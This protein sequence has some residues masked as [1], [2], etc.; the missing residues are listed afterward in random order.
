MLITCV[1]HQLVGRPRREPF[2][3][4]ACAISE[5]VIMF[6]WHPLS[7]PIETAAKERGR[8]SIAGTPSPSLL[9]RLLKREGGVALLAPPLRPY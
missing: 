7:V 2:D 4:R 8:C 1:V 5:T 6:C 3:R 9:K